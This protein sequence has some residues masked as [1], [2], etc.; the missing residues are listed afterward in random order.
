MCKNREKEK[1]KRLHNLSPCIM[2]SLLDLGSRSPVAV[3]SGSGSEAAKLLGGGTLSG[4][5]ADTRI[6]VAGGQGMARVHVV[7]LLGGLMVLM[8]GIPS[9]VGLGR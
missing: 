6:R 8:V 9:R 5:S 4:R 2:A 7:L 3:L 1:K